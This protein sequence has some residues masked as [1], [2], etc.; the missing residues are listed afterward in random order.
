MLYTIYQG[1]TQTRLPAEN[2]RILHAADLHLGAGRTH[3]SV[4]DRE[5]KTE[6]FST[7][8]RLLQ[9]A[10]EKRVHLLLLAGD[11]LEATQITPGELRAVFY[12][13]EQLPCPVLIAPGNHDPYVPG[14]FYLDTDLPKHVHV[15][16]GEWEGVFFPQLRTTIW[17]CG[18]TRVAVH[19][20][21]WPAGSYHDWLQAMNIED[22]EG[23]HLACVHGQ[24]GAA[25]LHAPY[26]PL[27]EVKFSAS[28]LHYIALGHVHKRQVQ[29]GKTT[30]AYS[31][32]LQG[33]GFDEPGAHGAL[34]VE[35]KEGQAVQ[36]E[37]I[38]L[39]AREFRILP[40]ELVYKPAASAMALDIVDRV[41]SLHPDYKNHSYRLLLKGKMPID[42]R[43]SLRQIQAR[44]E[45]YFYHV[46]LAEAFS[47]VYDLQTLA[48]ER[49]LRG[50]IVRAALEDI[51]AAAD[52]TAK[53]K[54]EKALYLV[55]QAFEGDIFYEENQP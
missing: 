33:N 40:L 2:L 38:P 20:S 51:E 16:R 36:V 8:Q 43:L 29:I 27:T 24:V 23:L 6:V 19:D 54:L 53:E 15:F 3:G 35:I 39:A 25:S 47:Y 48:K 28:E 34:S 18:F 10:Q 11:F 41:E 42:A 37:F 26:N 44:V 13:L 14:S 50:L 52:E 9:A 12:E 7:F 4:K 22:K 31:G 17:G 5:R 32:S 1:A 55:L 46:E 21:L 49:T 30:W 45:S